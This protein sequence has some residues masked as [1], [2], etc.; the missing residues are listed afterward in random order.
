[1]LHWTALIVRGGLLTAYGLRVVHKKK[2]P[3]SHA[4]NTCDS[5]AN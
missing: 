2:A 4:I 3:L 5:G 1:M